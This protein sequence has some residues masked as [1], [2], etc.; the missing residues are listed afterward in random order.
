LIER[1]DFV[2]VDTIDE[3]AYYL[4]RYRA[5]DAPLSSNAMICLPTLSVDK[6]GEMLDRFHPN[7]TL[8][9]EPFELPYRF[10]HRQR[11]EILL[12]VLGTRL[13]LA[14]DAEDSNLGRACLRTPDRGA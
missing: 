12:P 13:V 14:L 6:P 4:L 2:V 10:S 5:S 1:V 8:M 3:L 7:S 9:L 11:H